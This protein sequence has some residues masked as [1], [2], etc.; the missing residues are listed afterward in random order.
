MPILTFLVENKQS[1]EVCV[2]KCANKVIYWPSEP[3]KQNQLVNVHHN[4]LAKIIEIKETN[5]H[6][7]V[8]EELCVTISF[9]ANLLKSKTSTN[10]FPMNSLPCRLASVLPISEDNAKIV[11]Q[12]L[13]A[14]LIEMHKVGLPHPIFQVSSLSLKSVLLHSIK[15]SWTDEQN[16]LARCQWLFVS[17][18][19]GSC[20]GPLHKWLHDSQYASYKHTLREMHWSLFD[21]PLTIKNEIGCTRDL[22]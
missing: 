15:F 20:T 11:C 19:C 21:N 14:A 5:E 6:Y 12:N 13:A 18:D 17:G 10:S 1:K 4:N 2:L 8:V 3:D 22:E 9:V 7:F 16:L